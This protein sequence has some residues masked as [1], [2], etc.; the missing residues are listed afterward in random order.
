VA[1]QGSSGPATEHARHRWYLPCLRA[2]P[3]WRAVVGPRTGP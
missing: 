3:R 1:R 2:Q